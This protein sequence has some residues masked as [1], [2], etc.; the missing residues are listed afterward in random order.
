MKACDTRQ[1]SGT[2][3]VDGPGSRTAVVSAVDKLHK[4]MR[5]QCRLCMGA[6]HWSWGAQ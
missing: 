1:T 5:L 2:S 3:D 4:S 6:E